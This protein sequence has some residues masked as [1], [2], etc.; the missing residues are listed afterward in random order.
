M[1][2]LL[3]EIRIKRKSYWNK[4]AVYSHNTSL[5]EPTRGD[6]GGLPPGQGVWG[7]GAPHAGIKGL[8]PLM[9]FN[10]YQEK[11]KLEKIIN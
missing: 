9:A 5:R 10:S 1:I 11:D 6:P 4:K 3:F 7:V 8:Q 2:M